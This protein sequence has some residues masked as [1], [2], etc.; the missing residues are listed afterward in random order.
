M[1]PDSRHGH[2][3]VNAMTIAKEF[4][5][6]GDEVSLIFDGGGTTWI[7]ELASDEH[8]AHRRAARFL[9]FTGHSLIF[10]D[11]NADQDADETE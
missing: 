5:E 7:P 9:G 4:K 3:I 10:R 1:S 2:P 8:R 11:H 6:A